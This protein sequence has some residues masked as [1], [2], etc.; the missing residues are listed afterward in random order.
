MFVDPVILVGIQA[1]DRLKV[2]QHLLKARAREPN[3]L[4]FS[5]GAIRNASHEALVFED[6]QPARGSA[7]R[8]KT[9]GSHSLWRKEPFLNLPDKEIEQDVPRG[10]SVNILV[11][12]EPNPA[13]SFLYG[14]MSTLRCQFDPAH[15]A[16]LPRRSGCTTGRNADVIQ[17]VLCGI[18]L[19]RQPLSVDV[20][21]SPI[22]CP[23]QRARI[24]RRFGRG[25]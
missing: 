2:T 3:H 7:F 25:P 8:S 16:G 14:A 12:D 17:D 20:H 18:Q 13:L 1:G 5:V 4:A 22:F 19:C 21:H 11:A 9:V 23:A 15:K 24:L 6:L 10:V